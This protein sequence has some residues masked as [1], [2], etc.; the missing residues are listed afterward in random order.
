MEIRRDTNNPV[1]QRNHV[2]C[3]MLPL[4][5]IMIETTKIPLA[6]R[7]FVE[8]FGENAPEEARRRARER[9]LFGKAEGYDT[10]MLIYEQVK[11]LVEGESKKTEP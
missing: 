9:K 1:F 4:G 6:A 10:W 5:G 8:R 3:A 2:S 7:N 11:I